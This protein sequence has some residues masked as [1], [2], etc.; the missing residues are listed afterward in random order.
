M[1]LVLVCY[2][3]NLEPEPCSHII[4]DGLPPEVLGLKQS[5]EGRVSLQSLVLLL[6][7]EQVES[8]GRTV[9]EFPDELKSLVKYGLHDSPIKRRNVMEN[10]FQSCL[11]VDLNRIGFDVEDD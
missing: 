8:D 6:Y 7:M 5:F 2:L 11:S 3:Q 4:L 10:S 9:S 1:R